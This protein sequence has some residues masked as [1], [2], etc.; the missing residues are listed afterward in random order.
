L[1]VLNKTLVGNKLAIAPMAAK[2]IKK[3]K[4]KHLISV[5]V[6]VSY[7]DVTPESQSSG[8]RSEV[9]FLGKGY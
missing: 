5:H 3:H 6:P 9:D 7:C 2:R 4:F 8:V 1:V